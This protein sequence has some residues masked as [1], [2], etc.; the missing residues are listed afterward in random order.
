MT[1]REGPELEVLLQRVAQTP[2]DFLAEPALAGRPGVQVPAVVGDL[3][4]MLGQP[5]S[6]AA[7][8][9][10][11]SGA[12]SERNRLAVTL[13]VSWVLAEPRL[14]SAAESGEALA[15]LL[16]GG[17]AELAQFTP[18]ARFVSDPD[19]REELVRFVLARLGLRPARES[20]AQAQDRLTSLSAAE[21]SR[22]L[23][24]ARVAEERARKIRE[25]LARKAAQES[26]DKWTRE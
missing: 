10:F 5:L 23:A 7:L 26:A 25:Q 22:V 20:V 12:K 11:A 18:S 13:L 19:R 8:A 2:Q 17:A 4:R 14:R 24:A 21:R 16:L 9:G 3:C 15:E 6:D 1:E